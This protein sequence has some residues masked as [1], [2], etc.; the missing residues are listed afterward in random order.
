MIIKVLKELGR[1]VNE[2]NEK[3]EVFNRVRKYKEES[4]LKSPS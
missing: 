4:E 1:R 3:V 2:Q